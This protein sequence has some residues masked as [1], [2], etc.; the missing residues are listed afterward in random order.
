HAANASGTA[1]ARAFML[2]RIIF[3]SIAPSAD[4][5]GLQ[6]AARGLERKR[7]TRIR[8]HEH[9]SVGETNL[10]SRYAKSR[11][12]LRAKLLRNLICRISRCGRNGISRRAATRARALR[13]CGVA[14]FNS[15][16]GWLQT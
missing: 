5:F 4:R 15:D 11:R 9:F 6:P 8:F 12:D 7:F 2:D 13:K 1:S 3:A 14:N 16:I 10:I